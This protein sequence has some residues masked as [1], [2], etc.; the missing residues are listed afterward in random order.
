MAP[1]PTPEWADAVFPELP[2]AERI[3]ALWRAIGA[4]C[5]LETASPPDAW[6]EHLAGLEGKRNALEARGQR[7]LRY[8]GPGTDLRVALPARHRWCTAQLR[9]PAGQVFVPNLPTEEVFTAPQPGSAEGVLRVARP[10]AVDGRV[11]RGIE[12]EFRGGEIVEARAEEG[13]EALQHLLETDDGA[14]RLGELAW[15]PRD[16]AI[17]RT[18]RCFLHPLLDENALPHVALGDGYAFT[19]APDAQE[20]LNR[21]AV[22][23]DLPIDADVEFE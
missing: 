17:A 22:H 19:L 21:S 11:V 10:V 1:A 18:G 12:L 7:A 16:T 13:A 23:L 5:R 15:V 14:T 9:T 4:A 8:R 3:D 6:R 20:T 2:A